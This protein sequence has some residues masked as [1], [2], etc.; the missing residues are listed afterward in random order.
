[1]QIKVNEN[2]KEVSDSTTLFELRDQVRS[3]ADVVVLNGAPATDDVIL[4]DGD[5]VVLIV[6]GQIPKHDELESLMTARHTPGVHD[7]VKKTTVGIAGLGGLGSAIAIA[8]ARV[9]VGKLILADFDVVEPSN[10]NRQQYFIDQIGMYKT[11][12]LKQNLQRINPY[13]ELEMHTVLLTSENVPQI[14]G[15]VDIL[16][17]AFDSPNAKAMLLETFSKSNP[18]KQIVMASGLAGFEAGNTIITRKMGKTLTIVGDL[19][20][21]AKPGTGLMPPRVGIAAHH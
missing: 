21:E 19:V 10:L 14:F 20:T 1:M 11:D 8:L 12:A 3:K 16:V 13:V 18:E 9:G 15:D 4:K 17:E 5:Q 7:A 2:F 6:K